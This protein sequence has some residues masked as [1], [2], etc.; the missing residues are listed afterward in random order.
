M[1]DFFLICPEGARLNYDGGTWVSCHG[2]PSNNDPNNVRWINPTAEEL[3]EYLSVD[4]ADNGS[5]IDILFTPILST[6]DYLILFSS[7]ALYF[8]TCWG[9]STLGKAIN[10]R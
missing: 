3:A 8:A 9:F 2:S 5:I 4:L 6:N 1:D 10:P 7:V